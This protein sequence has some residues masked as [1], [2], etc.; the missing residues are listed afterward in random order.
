MDQL[1][2]DAILWGLVGGL[3]FLV[4]A[5]GFELATARGIDALVKVGGTVVV[6]VVA[7]AV[8]YLT[9]RRL[10]PANERT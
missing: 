5:Q 9:R 6:T 8:V 3:S 4:L 10:P 1:L 2:R 7:T